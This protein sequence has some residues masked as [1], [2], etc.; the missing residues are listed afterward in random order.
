VALSQLQNLLGLLLGEPV[1]LLECSESVSVNLK[2]SVRLFLDEDKIAEAAITE[3][4]DDQSVRTENLVRDEALSVRKFFDISFEKIKS[5]EFFQGILRLA[6]HINAN[7]DCGITTLGPVKKVEADTPQVLNFLVRGAR[8]TCMI[9]IL[10]VSSLE[11][12]GRSLNFV[13]SARSV[14]DSR[15]AV[16]SLFIPNPSCGVR[17]FTQ[18]VARAPGVT[19]IG[20]IGHLGCFLIKEVVMGDTENENIQAEIKLGSIS[21]KLKD[22]FELRPGSEIELD[23]PVDSRGMLSIGGNKWAEVKIKLGQEKISLI[24][25]NDATFSA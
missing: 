5:P 7:P 14:E 12:L 2:R 22:L 15:E 25:A 19:L 4:R 24:L 1:K 23:W 3:A 17:E 21:L 9:S 8:L 20:Q 18:V 13:A 6:Q 11:S 16:L 10:G